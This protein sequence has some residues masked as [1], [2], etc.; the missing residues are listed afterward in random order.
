MTLQSKR[1]VVLTTLL[2]SCHPAARYP[3]TAPSRNAPFE[4][5]EVRTLNEDYQRT[6]AV[7][8][9][10]EVQTP[11]RAA[12]DYAAY[13][14]N[15]IIADPEPE[16]E[17]DPAAKPTFDQPAP[18][19]GVVDKSTLSADL[20]TTPLTESERTHPLSL[21]PMLEFLHSSKVD[22]AKELEQAGAQVRDEAW[23]LPRRPGISNQSIAE[24]FVHA[25]GGSRELWAKIEFQPWLKRA[26]SLP[27]QDGDGV[28]ELYGRL[29]PS[30]IKP[31]IWSSIEDDYRKRRLSREEVGT[32]ANRLASYW[33]PSFNTDL[34]P[35]GTAWPDS[36]TEAEVKK[37]LGERSYPAPTIVLRGKPQGNATYQVFFVKGLGDG[38]S[39]PARAAGPALK[40]TK[41]APTPQPDATRAAIER[42][43]REH[44]GS[45]ERWAQSTAPA[46]ESLRRHARSLRGKVKALEGKDGFLFFKNS[47]EYAAAPE[48]ER[49]KKGKNPLPII[50]EF[51]KALAA[52]GVDFLFVPVPTKVEVYPDRLDPKLASYAGQ[53]VNPQ[54]RKFLLALANA[55]VEVV[56][57]LPAFLAARRAQSGELVFQRQDTHW[58][59]SGLRLAADILS[60][61][62]KKY[63]WYKELSRHAQ[64][65]TTR[66]AK[67]QRLG[68]L[69]SRL[70]DAV[71]SRYEPEQLIAQQVIGSNG[72]PYV[73]DPD[74][75]IVVLG[76]SFTGVYQL[77]DAEHA[78]LSAHMAK[79]VG[80]PIDLV[81]SYGGGPNVRHKLMRRGTDALESK[82]LVVWVMTARDL[83]NYWEDWEPLG[84]K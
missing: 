7:V 62:I 53:V 34:V 46:A 81:M 26:W 67:F 54:G 71:K 31:A 22:G 63:P 17:L 45:F 43:L 24:V 41:T 12:L 47:L 57:L 14:A 78:G 19:G 4:H 30:V 69:H 61:R 25:S 74:S 28:P 40:L 79:D 60:E 77:M 84:G 51:Q 72:E 15:F 80:Y 36:H 20:Y 75:P 50:V 33:Y 59:D 70:P 48:L 58:T 5:A 55:G 6:N 29:D 66:E 11:T 32:W 73:D 23:G 16:G 64:R 49:Q 83:Y 13:H 65:F 68:D 39:Q 8:L 2:V 76:D 52:Q 18:F 3:W 10:R 1:A 42:E 9:L 21:A 35:P 44:G 82:K 38:E 56:D 27:D 37:S